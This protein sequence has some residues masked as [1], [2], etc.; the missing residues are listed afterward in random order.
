MADPNSEVVKVLTTCTICYI[1]TTTT[2]I[3]CGLRPDQ[4]KRNIRG[5]LI[6]R[7]WAEERLMHEAAAL[8]FISEKTTIPVPKV[9]GCG[10]RAGVP[11]LELERI[12]GI[13]FED[14]GEICRMPHQAGHHPGEPCSTCQQI[15]TTNVERFITD[16]V[17]PQLSQLKS[18]TTGFNGFV[19][20]PVW[21]L[22]Y[23]RRP[24]WEPKTSETAEYIF[25]LG[26][27]SAHNIMCDPVTLEVTYLYDLEHSGFFPPEFQRWTTN[28]PAYHELFTNTDR[29]RKLISLIEPEKGSSNCRLD[30][31]A[32]PGST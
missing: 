7:L 6:I 17:L 1:I 32:A 12:D 3:K 5:E 18:K 30:E 31:T 10:R 23:D 9:I 29:I 27:L 4:L 16:V 26:D 28:R 15:A 25:V 13:M 24:R 19:I 8:K 14:V 2:F 21:M 20:P 11:Y 22:E